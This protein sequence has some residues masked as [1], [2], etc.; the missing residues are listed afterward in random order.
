VHNIAPSLSLSLFL[1]LFL[2]HVNLALTDLW[3][4]MNY[5]YRRGGRVILKLVLS[6]CEKFLWER[7]VSLHS[8]VVAC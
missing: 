2:S 1:F 7:P 4:A 8:D 5:K 3:P 6:A